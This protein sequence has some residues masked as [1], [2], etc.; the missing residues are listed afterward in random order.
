MPNRIIKESICTSRKINLLTPEEEVFFYRLL[1]NCDDYGCFFAEPDLLAGKLYP[2][3]RLEEQEM[4]RI[5]DRLAEVGLIV[6]YE[7]KGE[8]YLYLPSWAEHQRVRTKKRRFP[9]PDG[10][11]AENNAGGNVSPQVAASCS[12]MRPTRAPAESESES[13][14]NPNP[15]T[16]P[17]TN[18][19]PNS[20]SGSACVGVQQEEKKKFAEFVSLTNAEYEAL[21]AKVGKQGAERCIELLD[22]YKGST[23]KT[24][25]SDYRAMLNWVVKRYEEEQSREKAIR[26]KS[27]ATS[28]DPEEFDR[29]GLSLPD[30]EEVTQ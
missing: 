20:A 17:N 28:Y 10:Q 13:E 11:N 21:V 18:P 5:R 27:V 6:L 29:R 4:L 19:N 8:M 30:I 24:Y 26:P 16:N 3:R 14:S 12:E 22:N 1:V 23:G 9:P 7:H 25:K 15:N 2:R